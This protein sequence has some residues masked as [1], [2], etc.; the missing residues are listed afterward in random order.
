MKTSAWNATLLTAL[1]LAP[2]GFAKGDEQQPPSAPVPPAAPG[3][4]E[5][6]I[7]PA[8][9]A[10]RA[11]TKRVVVASPEKQVVVDGD[12]VLISGDDEDVLADLDGFD[13][14][15]GHSLVL[16]LPGHQAGGFIGIQPVEMTPDLRQH[17][18]APRDAGVFV[19]SVEADGPAAKAG[20]QVGD[21]VT[22]VDGDQIGSPRELV[23]LVRHKKGGE[24]ITVDVLRGKAAKT[25]TVTVAERKG[26]EVRIGELPE[27]RH[28]HDGTWSWQPF[29]TPP[30]LPS[31]YEQRLDQLEKKLRELEDRLPAR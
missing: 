6:P 22:K 4:P 25:L 9:P 27:K 24:T 14:W 30:G 16:P 18:G 26:S 29:A 15:D 31:D 19:G 10:P 20:L 3:A 28:G 11:R 8:P 7:P 2:S 17:F 13:A 12:R 1:L 21:I 23:R 5:A